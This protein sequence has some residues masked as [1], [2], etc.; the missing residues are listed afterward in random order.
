MI[1]KIKILL[2][3]LL[4]HGV[5][6]VTAQN[7]ILTCGETTDSLVKFSG[8]TTLCNNDTIP[9]S[10]NVLD[11]TSTLPN[12]AYIIEAPNDLIIFEQGDTPITPAQLEAKD[13]DTLYVTGIAYDLV[14]INGLIEFLS[15]FETCRENGE[16]GVNTCLAISYVNDQ[17]G[18]KRLDEGIDLL[19]EVDALP[20][21]PT[22]ENVISLAINLDEE[23]SSA[24][25]FCVAFS[26]N[27]FGK[28]YYYIVNNWS[29]AQLS[30]TLNNVIDVASS[31][32][33][34]EVIFLDQGFYTNS[35]FYAAIEN[36][37]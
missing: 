27:G 16:R 37:E 13:G 31:Y 2:I 32:I 19:I 26:N 4:C 25:G 8:K 22:T 12:Y 29:S 15:D 10:Y 9:L 7:L 5:F 17:G 35:D 1:N 23:A 11:N 28:D 36:C 6:A 33:A 30:I 21:M 3:V 24:D 20:P 18:I 14:E 34:K